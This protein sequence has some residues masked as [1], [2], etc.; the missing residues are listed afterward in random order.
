MKM[1][2]LE[3]KTKKNEK[4]V[5]FTSRPKKMKTSCLEF[6]TNK[7]KGKVLRSRL[8]ILKNFR[9]KNGLLN[10]AGSETPQIGEYVY[11]M[12]ELWIVI[13]KISLGVYRVESC[14]SRTRKMSTIELLAPTKI[15]SRALQTEVELQN[16]CAQSEK[17]KSTNSLLQKD[18]VELQKN[19]HKYCDKAK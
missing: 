19:L 3:F 15:R 7:N 4:R 2:C 12:P 14:L 5:V 17:L 11:Y 18:L 6:K 16:Q 8:K 13:S 9:S 10:I 1:S